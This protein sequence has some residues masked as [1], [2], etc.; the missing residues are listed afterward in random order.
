MKFFFVNVSKGE[1]VFEAF[2]L[3]NHHFGGDMFLL[4]FLMIIYSMFVYFQVR[5]HM[6]YFLMKIPLAKNVSEKHINDKTSGP[7][8]SCVLYADVAIK[9]Y[10]ISLQTGSTFDGFIGCTLEQ[11][12]FTTYNFTI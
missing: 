4:Y 6:Y 5:P 11:L 7:V 8:E 10:A 1:F 3:G 9:S 12:N 2:L